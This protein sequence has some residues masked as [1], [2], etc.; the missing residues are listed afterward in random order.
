MAQEEATNH[1]PN[2][3]EPLP[4]SA[5]AMQ[6]SAFAE[7]RRV[8]ACA[9]EPF[10]LTIVAFA[11]AGWIVE[12][13]VKRVKTPH[14]AAILPTWRRRTLP[15]LALVAGLLLLAGCDA[16]ATTLQSLPI[17]SSAN[18][19]QITLPGAGEAGAVDAQAAGRPAE[20]RI[21]NIPLA[22][23][24]AS[25]NA[26]ISGMAWF[27]EMLI[28][29]PQWPDFA[30]DGSNILFALPRAQIEAAIDGQSRDRLTPMALALDDAALRAALPTF[31]GYEAIAFS[32][33][34]VY[35][36]IETWAPMGSAGY[37]VRG[38]VDRDNAVVRIDPASLVEI[39]PQT[40]KVNVSDEAIVITG[41]GLLTIYELNGVLVND[42]P[43]AHRFTLDGHP[44]EPAPFP[45]IEY[46]ITD[47]TPLDADGRFWAFNFFF[48]A[49]GLEVV[50]PEALAQSYG[51][52]ATHARSVQVERLVEFAWDGTQVVR[53][54][55][56][57]LQLQLGLVARNWEGLVR[58]GDRGFLIVTDK[59]PVTM[60][61]FV[62]K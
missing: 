26:E 3:G 12:K 1:R 48:P 59:Y 41:D 46:R 31:G 50:E 43:I 16:V 37:L 13:Q 39:P 2:G 58:L 54:E 35:L 6:A 9:G 10:V 22:G 42:A 24:A 52:G 51:E 36:T 56:P 45:A 21:T 28:L 14:S 7:S 61:G 18:G 27:D 60:L 53:T 30:G 20:V 25:R 32:G 23:P 49:E 11:E 47:A 19:L 62:E 44:L 5:D 29:L 34:T 40:G 55:T 17:S 57:P 15:L 33:D 8:P 4:H 38:S